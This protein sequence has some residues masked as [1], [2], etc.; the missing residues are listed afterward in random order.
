IVAST[1]IRTTFDIAWTCLSVVLL[2]TW[3]VLHLNVPAE[4]VKVNIRRKIYLFGR[5]VWWWLVA[6]FAPELIA[7]GCTVKFLAARHV[8]IMMQGW[9]AEDGVTWAL[10]HAFFATMGGFAIE[11][12]EGLIKVEQLGTTEAT[13]GRQLVEARKRGIIS[14]LPQVT[15]AEIEDRSKADAVTKFLA[16]V[17]TTWFVTELVLRTVTRLPISQIEIHTAAMVACS[18]VAYAANWHRPQN[19]MTRVKL[20]A[21]R[22]PNAEDIREIASQGGN[23][24]WL[25]RSPTSISNDNIHDC[26]IAFSDRLR[27]T[28]LNEVLPMHMT[29]VSFGLVFAAVHFAAWGFE[30]PTPQEQLGWRVACFV[31]LATPI[32][33]SLMMLH[34]EYLTK[35]HFATRLLA[36]VE[37]NVVILLEVIY[38]FARLFILAE[39][40]RT[41]FYLPA[42]AYTATALWNVPHL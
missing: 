18:T 37:S 10:P 8:N 14:R 6:L 19:I 3:A 7:S 2:C 32:P 27:S 1:R 29:G 4:T 12:E 16:L 17:Q 33:V 35:R 21:D 31:L 41:L 13:G 20:R 42:G 40:V 25:R 24:Q 11:F 22:L 15:E 36:V 5:S 30:F 9:A 39:V 23:P 38:V 28:K 26:G 34:A